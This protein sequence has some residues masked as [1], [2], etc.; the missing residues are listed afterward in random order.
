MSK[1][2]IAVSQGFIVPHTSRRC[3]ES[4]SDQLLGLGMPT[5]TDELSK[6][7][8]VPVR[9]PGR[10]VLRSAIPNRVLVELQQFGGRSAVDHGTQ[11]AV[12]DG[13][14]LGPLFRWLCVVEM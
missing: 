10:T 9:I 2:K 5:L 4:R 7:G 3:K 8:K 6:Q 14:G 11:A 13:Q 12:A 1:L